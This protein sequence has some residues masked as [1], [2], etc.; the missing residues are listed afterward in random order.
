MQGRAKLAAVA[1][2]FNQSIPRTGTAANAART[3]CVRP[4]VAHCS[5][6]RTCIA[7]FATLI[8][9]ASL[10]AQRLLDLPV[11]TATT[12]DAVVTGAPAAFWNPAG[13]ARLGGRAEASV[14]DVR[15]PESIGIGAFALAAAIRLDAR[16]S[17][18]FG[19]QH[20]G[21]EDIQRTGTNPLPEPGLG[22]F[23][24]GEDL[25]ALV[26]ARRLVDAV[27]VG[28]T[29]RY[30]RTSEI[31]RDRSIIEYGAGLDVRPALPLLP[32]LAGGARAEDDGTAWF[33]GLELTPWTAPM[34]RWSVR[35]SWGL[36]EGPRQ[37]GM[38]HRIAAAGGWTDRV[39]VSAGVQGE[40]G[41]DGMTWQ[42][43]GGLVIRI[44]RYQ[45]GILREEL[46]NGFGAF[47]SFH[48]GVSF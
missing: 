47:H 30:V 39:S 31:V 7:L 38:S 44:S 33:A 5:T 8:P 6:S 21:T 48:F 46:P 25:F 11:R 20:T 13:I 34:R 35:T 4:G 36:S 43:A 22:D 29:A 42:P 28:V 1:K 40:P 24:V 10:Q 45:L 3:R 9:T 27:A 32:V 14:V 23:N 26:A 41:A 12:A 18:G 2:W 17:I 37:H 16:T 15:G 19:F